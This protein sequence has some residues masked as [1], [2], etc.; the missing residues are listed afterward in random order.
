MESPIFSWIRMRLISRVHD[1]SPVHRVDAHQY[2]EEIGSLR[3][4]K[5]S[6]LTGRSLSLNP[7]FTRSRK[8]LPGNQKRNYIR[9]QTVPRNGAAHDVVIVTSVTMAYEIGVVFVEPDLT[10]GGDLPVPPAHAFG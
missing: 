3:D 4:L 6:G 9:Y 7:E 1:G 2:T 10:L 5:H 8:D